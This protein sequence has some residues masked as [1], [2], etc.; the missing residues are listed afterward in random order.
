MKG[1]GAPVGARS[2]VFRSQL[3]RLIFAVLALSAMT[4]AEGRDES[5]RK[6]GLAQLDRTRNGV[7]E[8]VKGLSEAQWRFKPAPERWSVAEILEHLA[9]AE[10]M[11]L[12]HISKKVMQAPAGNADRDYKAIDELVL[13]AIADRTQRVQA[14]ESMVPTGR[15]PPQESLDR[16]LKRRERTAEFLRTTPGLRDHVVDS[17]L[18]QPMDAF[19][20]LLFIAA[21]S[22]R[23]TKQILEVKA[24]P[25]FP[26]GGH[27]GG[28]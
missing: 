28:V 22:E 16:F 27:D 2:D 25:G 3:P 7:V 12:A 14:P 1:I 6:E 8:A 19:Q 24:D 9:L 4:A 11:L 20:Y 10:D 15:W 23:H 26:V 21:H 17:P 5:D 13:K 18:G